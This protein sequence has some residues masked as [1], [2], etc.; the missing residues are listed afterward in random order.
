METKQL[1]EICNTRPATPVT[2]QFAKTLPTNQSASQEVSPGVTTIK[3][4]DGKEYKVTT[5]GQQE[6]RICG[7]C[8]AK[9]KASGIFMSGLGCLG[10]LLGGML[11]LGAL[12]ALVAALI[13]SGQFA[14]I[15]Q[16]IGT[17]GALLFLG[18][19]YSATQPF[20]KART[21][22]KENIVIAMKRAELV[23]HGFN[24]FWANDVI[25]D[26]PQKA[27]VVAQPN[28]Q[29]SQTDAVAKEPQVTIQERKTRI[30]SGLCPKCGNSV[31]PTDV[32]C[33]SCKVN[34]N[35]AREHLND[36]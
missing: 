36:W 19:C 22:K 1:C 8:F 27:N 24:L 3:L 12:G 28:E 30:A 35:F 4:P 14:S 26:I 31:K 20:F 21:A 17:I 9:R 25:E 10:T 23:M 6:V 5:T 2:L 15:Q 32:S 29:I 33:P 34:L 11:V 13:P 16:P 7:V 18:L